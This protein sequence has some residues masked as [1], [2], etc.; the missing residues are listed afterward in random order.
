M[1]AWFDHLGMEDWGG[2]RSSLSELQPP[3]DGPQF[4]YLLQNWGDDKAKAYRKVKT[5][6]DS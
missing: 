4:L 5:S 1:I 6:C 3:L 2:L